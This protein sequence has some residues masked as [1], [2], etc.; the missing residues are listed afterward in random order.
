MFQ[1][2]IIDLTPDIKLIPLSIFD[3][4]LQ[5]NFNLLVNDTFYLSNNWSHYL[6]FYLLFR[7]FHYQDFPFDQSDALTQPCHIRSIKKQK[8]NFR[9][10]GCD[11]IYTH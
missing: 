11:I 3:S 4:L 10:F 1:K 8:I 7:F 9:S 2:H 5:L 6:D